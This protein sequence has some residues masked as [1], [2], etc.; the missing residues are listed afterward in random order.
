MRLDKLLVELQIGSR[1][2]VKALVKK[3]LIFVD[4]VRAK[5]PEDKVD[6]NTVTIT[7][8]DRDYIYQQYFYY[9]MN[10]PAGVITA[11]E[12]GREA[13]VM[14]IFYRVF[15]EGKRDLFPVGRLD[16][17][18]T[19]LLL[20][21]NDG[22][23]AHDMLSPKKHV[24]K[25]YFVG[26]DGALTSENVE[27]LEAGVHIGQ[28]E[29]TAPA[30]VEYSG[31]NTCYITIHEGHFHQVKRMFFAVGRQVVSLK[32]VAFGPLTLDEEDLPE[33]SVKEISRPEI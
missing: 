10:K 2:E 16:K 24:D 31:G 6:E 9:I 12:D 11:T 3:G 27:A 30:T 13:T 25:K 5:K 7:Y 23:L 22:A 33:G 1:S 14:D 8:G 32:R 20:I 21:T 28:G 18:T 4:G 26:L 15:P 29:L 17:D 19:G